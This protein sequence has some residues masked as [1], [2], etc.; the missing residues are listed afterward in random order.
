MKKHSLLLLLAVTVSVAS[1]YAKSLPSW[2]DTASKQ[3]LVSF[4]EGVCDEGGSNFV[5]PGERIAVF[6]NDGTLWS[7]QP[8]YFQLIFAMDRVKALAPEHP[9]W[10]TEEPFASVLRGD[11]HSVLASDKKGLLQLV[12]AS[13]AGLTDEQFREVVRDWLATARHPETN[14]PYNEMIYQPMLEVL[15][16]L[17][18]NGFKTFI[19]SGGGVDFLRVWSEEAYGIPPEQ[20]VGSSLK[21]GYE[22]RD[23][24]P[25]IVKLP[26][27]NFIDDKEGKPVG[28][29]Q[30][31]G[32]R[33]IAAFGN[34]DGDFQMIEW[35]TSGE[36]ARFGMIIHHD[37]AKREWAYDHES[38]IGKLVRGLD[39]GSKRG[40]TIVSMKSDWKTI[41]TA[42]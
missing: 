23:G 31:I 8:L 19:V 4:V 22:I 36:G 41:Y 30:H 13:H 24:A 7:E 37:D 32:R 17:R 28:I 14:R 25:V 20:V 21:A 38:H 6:D 12:A 26:E 18:A 34:S 35:T 29:H 40:W 9:E 5:P 27:L 3:A 42:E 33:P 16:Y 11:L 2:H 15:D 10:K 1:A 39:E